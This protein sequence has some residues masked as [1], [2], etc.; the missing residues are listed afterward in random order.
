MAAPE[1]FKQRVQLYI[2]FFRDGLES[3]HSDSF[4]LTPE[5]GTVREIAVAKPWYQ[6]KRA[7]EGLSNK[8]GK[9]QKVKSDI[10]PGEIELTIISGF[11]ICP[12]YVI[13][14]NE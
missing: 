8:Q 5:A 11:C 4:Q 13:S 7:L 14:G 1:V 12:A 9:E 2:H 6:P 3:Q 10:S